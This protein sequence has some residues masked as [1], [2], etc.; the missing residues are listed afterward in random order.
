MLRLG[1]AGDPLGVSRPAPSGAHRHA[2]PEP[3][4]LNLKA[5]PRYLR[6][7]RNEKKLP[8]AIAWLFQKLDF[9]GSLK[10]A[11]LSPKR[12][13][14]ATSGFELELD[15]TRKSGAAGCSERACVA[16]AWPGERDFFW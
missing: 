14:A 5:T 10:A 13:S 9:E 2:R 8:F 7:L 16:R 15:E 11:K 12:P 4:G 6:L 3:P 1:R